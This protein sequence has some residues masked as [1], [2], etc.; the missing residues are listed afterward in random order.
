MNEATVT[1]VNDFAKATRVSKAK[2]TELVAAVIEANV[3]KDKRVYTK[4][5]KTLETIYNI[6]GG[7]GSTFTILEL[8]AK[9]VKS[10][11]YMVSKLESEGMVTRLED[12]KMNT[13]RGRPNAIYKLITS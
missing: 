3:T 5:D 1:L 10:A 11:R 6:V 7:F 13:T 4:S 12:M 9:G 8:E 2:L